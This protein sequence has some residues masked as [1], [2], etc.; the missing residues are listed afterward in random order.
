MAEGAASSAQERALHISARGA[1]RRPEV[2]VT[3][4]QCH[5]TADVVI[6]FFEVEIYKK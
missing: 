2:Q 3:A 5:P 1:L 4:I 6:D